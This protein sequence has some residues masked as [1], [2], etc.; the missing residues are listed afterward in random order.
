MT[1]FR[2]RPPSWT[3]EIQGATQ[4]A[5]D[6]GLRYRLQNGARSQ[7]RWRK[8]HSWRFSMAS[9]RRSEMPEPVHCD[10]KM[11]LAQLKYEVPSAPRTPSLPVY[12]LRARRDNSAAR[13]NR[14]KGTIQLALPLPG[15][16]S[17]PAEGEAASAGQASAARHDSNTS[18]RPQEYETRR[19]GW[20][21][22][23]GLS[24]AIVI[25]EIYIIRPPP[26]P[27]SPTPSRRP[28]SS[29]TAP[30]PPPRSPP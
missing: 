27:A 6:Q 3:W 9:P 4:R 29:E 11:E 26:L 24:M 1:R 15:Q 8:G 7:A 25:P 22:P 10:E 2:G 28:S 5:W 14:P 18:K 30:W 20:R 19:R 13:P 16:E 23:A 21:Q 12:S 17:G